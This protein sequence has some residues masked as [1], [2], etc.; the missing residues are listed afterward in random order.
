MIAVGM[1]VIVHVILIVGSELLS[2]IIHFNSIEKASIIYTNAG[3]LVIPLVSA[4]LGEEWVFYTTAFILVQ[5]ILMWT[6]GVNLIGQEKNLNIR[7][8][9]CNPNVIAMIIGIALF[10]LEIRL[11]AVIDSCVSGFGDMSVRRA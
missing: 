7:K 10:A 9:L 4:V 1:S 2:Y 5:T 11:P 3:Y 8:I 6:H